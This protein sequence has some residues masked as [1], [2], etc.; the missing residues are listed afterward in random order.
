M[1]AGV[2]CKSTVPFSTS[3]STTSSDLTLILAAWHHG[4]VPNESQS[5]PLRRESDDL[6]ATAAKV[7]EHVATLKARFAE[8]QSRYR[9][10]ARPQEEQE[11]S[12]AM[13]DQAR[14]IV[15]KGS[16]CFFQV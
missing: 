16:I 11:D 8:L 9:G 7:I 13:H 2:A 3:F 6:L 4:R 14:T 10:G 12:I 15:P 5:E 1:T